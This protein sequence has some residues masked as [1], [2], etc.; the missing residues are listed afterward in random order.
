V[1]ERSQQ[2][3]L[4][5]LQQRLY[6]ERAQTRFCGCVKLGVPVCL[7]ATSCVSR[8][9][10]ERRTP[11]VPQS[12]LFGFLRGEDKKH[13]SRRMYIQKKIEKIEKIEKMK[14]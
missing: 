10:S 11:L 7:G 13:Y 9:V 8:R 12:L 5:T 3:V 14:I 6:P 1:T 2:A 4:L